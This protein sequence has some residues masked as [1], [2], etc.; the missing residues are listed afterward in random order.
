MIR[1]IEL[2]KREM[3]NLKTL[4]FVVYITNRIIYIHYTGTPDLLSQLLPNMFT[5]QE[6]CAF[7]CMLLCRPG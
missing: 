2:T 3:A 6:A 1:N 7:A 5:D 4:H